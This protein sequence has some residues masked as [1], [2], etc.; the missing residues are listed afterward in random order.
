[1]KRTLN[2]K[3]DF[4]KLVATLIYIKGKI[5]AFEAE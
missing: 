5:K 1:M 3:I 4:E 2:P